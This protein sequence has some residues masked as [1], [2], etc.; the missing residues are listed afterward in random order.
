MRTGNADLATFEEGA[1][2]GQYG[3]G[4]EAYRFTKL[5]GTAG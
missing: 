1:Q 3:R 5:V 2:G 4:G